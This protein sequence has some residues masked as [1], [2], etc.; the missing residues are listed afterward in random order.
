M[1]HRTIFAL[2]LF[3]SS[4]HA[5][6]RT[7]SPSDVRLAAAV[8]REL[9]VDPAVGGAHVHASALDGVVELHGRV[10][11]L[12]MADAAIART[13][14]VQG[15]SAVLDRTQ[16]PRS[17]RRDATIERDVRDALSL[18]P[19]TASMTLTPRAT[20]SVV[21]IEGSAGSFAQAELAEEVVRSV[22]GVRNVV[23]RIAVARE[24]RNDN[25]VLADVR[26]ALRADRLVDEWLIETSV[27]NGTVRLRG[28]QPTVAARRRAIERSWVPGVASVDADA[29]RVRPDLPSD[30]RRPPEGYVYPDDREIATA[31]GAL[32]AHHPR[33]AGRE[34][35]VA[36]E[37]GIVTLRGEVDGMAAR[38]AAEEAAQSVSGVW[39][40]S[41]DLRVAS[42]LA[43][44][45][46][47]RRV[48]R[49]LAL[50]PVSA[51]LQVRANDGAIRLVGALP[52]QHAKMVVED[53]VAR[54]SGVRGID[55][56]LRAPAL[57][58][59]SDDVALREDVITRM[60]E[61]P[62]VDSRGVRVLVDGGTVM[63]RGRVDDRRAAARAVH[64][65]WSAGPREVLD[66]LRVE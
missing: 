14:M 49:A 28:E 54:V 51:A 21:V 50:I 66:D 18:D 38:R 42:A 59:P 3:A 25:D 64:A 29:L 34:L 23:S 4:A 46:L 63:L 9:A 40:V 26:S 12:R 1:T 57:L 6:T 27:A 61:D 44:R 55:S 47:E 32:L 22:R 62:Y 2:L 17:A 10:P 20:D 15:V 48:E 53:A 13:E 11:D 8:E 31:I 37:R 39:R 45:E 36:V 43:D 5:Q 65:A 19:T 16:P 52:S 24:M 56:G 7:M 60:E 30:L 58:R 35:D 33:L 41:N